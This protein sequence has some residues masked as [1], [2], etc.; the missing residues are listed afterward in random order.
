MQMDETLVVSKE[1]EFVIL[2]NSIVKIFEDVNISQKLIII[3][4]HMEADR[5]FAAKVIEK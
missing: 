4:F 1:V 5:L 2:I 3:A